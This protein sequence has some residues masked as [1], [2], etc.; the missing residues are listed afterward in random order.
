MV[1]SAYLRVFQPI[2]AFDAEERAHWERYLLH[3][4]RSPAIR[5][6]Y[7]DRVHGDGLGIMTPADGEHADVRIVDGRTFVSPWRVRLRVLAGML[8]FRESAPL[9]DLTDGFVSKADARKAGRELS[10]MR[11]RNPNSISFTHQSPWHVPIR[12]FVFFDDT[13]RRLRDDEHGR[14]R[15]RYRTTTRRAMRR[16]EDAVPAL[17]RADL[18]PISE[19]IL[20]LHQWMAT[21]DH[22]SILELDYASL[23]DLM[24]WDELDDDRSVRDVNEALA[25][26]QRYDYSPAAD[27]YQGVLGRWAEIRSREV[28]N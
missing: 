2:D 3:G 7:R 26:L 25:A 28:L 14:L 8:A 9:E 13:E 5:A 11:R 23:S 10:R 18:G 1:P 24:T 12:W 22:L 15:L 21:F 6:R 17:R 20:D 4:A 16:A 27:I 19:Y